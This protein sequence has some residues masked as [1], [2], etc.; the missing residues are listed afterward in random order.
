MATLKDYATDIEGYLLGLGYQVEYEDGDCMLGN[1]FV[2]TGNGI[3][4]SFTTIEKM[5]NFVDERH[6]DD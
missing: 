6:K 5:L 3:E 4:E 1:Y 2:L